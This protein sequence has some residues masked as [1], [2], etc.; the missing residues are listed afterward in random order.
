MAMPVETLCARARVCAH[1]EG[2]RTVTR[3][4]RMAAAGLP[5]LW[6]IGGVPAGGFAAQT[7]PAGQPPAKVERPA[8]TAEQPK[9]TAQPTVKAP[10][11]PTSAAKTANAPVAKR[12]AGLVGKVVAVTPKSRTVVVDVPL[13]K[14]TLRIGAAV[15]DQTR[16]LLGGKTA[17]LEALKEGERV[18]I[19]Y[20]RT[21]TGDVATALE[22][23]RS[24]VG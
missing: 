23:L 4:T 12:P 8:P 9:T 15:T 2:M 1:V 3:W 19:I 13:G 18:R 7:E 14:H 10:E 20:H 6:A 22:V 24:S 21:S 5:L 17:S 16:I 11:A